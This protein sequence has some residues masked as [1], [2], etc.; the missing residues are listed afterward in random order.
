MRRA[1]Q[2]VALLALAAAAAA[3]TP[4]AA[5]ARP[6][7]PAP[8]PHGRALRFDLQQ[9]AARQDAWCAYDGHCF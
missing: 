5:P 6:T 9:A 4:A 8:M 7:A 2:L 3:G 1:A